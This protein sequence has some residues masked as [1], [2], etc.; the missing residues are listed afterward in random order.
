MVVEFAVNGNQA[1]WN[2]R[3][4]NLYEHVLSHSATG[5]PWY[6]SFSLET[7]Y[8][9]GKWQ[10]LSFNCFHCVT[11]THQDRIS[12]GWFTCVPQPNPAEA[13]VDHLLLTI[14]FMTV[15]IIG[16]PVEDNNASEWVRIVAATYGCKILQLYEYNANVYG[17]DANC[18]WHPK[19]TRSCSI[20]DSW[21]PRWGIYASV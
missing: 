3:E 20:K 11:T 19:N 18:E 10:K 16:A 6:S 8:L 14:I 17:Y 5:A 21:L 1:L 7:F 15:F 2:P 12:K 13:K 9:P 4:R